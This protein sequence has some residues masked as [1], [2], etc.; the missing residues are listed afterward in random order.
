MSLD[1]NFVFRYFHEYSQTSVQVEN[2]MSTSR[3]NQSTM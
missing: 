1:K 2:Q 3:F